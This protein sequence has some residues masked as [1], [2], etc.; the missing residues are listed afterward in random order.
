MRALADRSP[1][2]PP[3]WC[4]PLGVLAL[5]AA[6]LLAYGPAVPGPFVLDDHAAIQANP[7]LRPPA[8]WLDA[9]RPPA[10]GSTVSG[11]PLLNASFALNARWGGETAADFRRVNLALHAIAAALLFQLIRRTLPRIAFP[12][13]GAT[14]VAWVAAFGWALHPLQ[15]SAVSYISQRAEVL[16][17]TSLL[18]LLVALEKSTRSRLPTAWAALAVLASAA[19]LLSKETAVV[20]PV[21][22]LLYDRTFLAGSLRQAWHR[23]RWLHLG[24]AA[25]WILP[26]TLWRPGELRGGTV[27]FDA[28]PTAW[29]HLQ[30]QVYAVGHYLKQV[31]WPHPLVFD[32]GE[33][34]V[35]GADQLLLPLV[36][37]TVLVI[38]TGWA[39]RRRPAAGFCGAA[40][41][42][43]LAPSTALPIASQ[44]IAEHRMYLPLAAI[45]GCIAPALARVAGP[46]R[47]ALVLGSV[48]LA[49]GALTWQRN[50]V[51]RSDVAL[52]SDTVHRA[53]YNLRAHVNLGTAWLEAGQ[54]EDALTAYRTAATMQPEDPEIQLA[55]AQALTRLGRFAEAIRH[56][57][58]AVALAPDLRL[59]HLHLAE[60]YR[61]AGRWADAAET[62][63][64][65]LRL[66][67][68]DRDVRTIAAQALA[69]L[70]VR[71]PR[72][73]RER[74][75]V[76]LSRARELAP[77]DA[78]IAFTEGNGWAAAGEFHA[79]IEAYRR[80]LAIDATLVAARNNLAN[81]LLIVGRV[82]EAIVEYE[83]VLAA[84]PDDRSVRENLAAA[85]GMH[86]RRP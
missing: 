72:H 21:L 25:T 12:A 66:A 57:E 40:I 22:A 79:A 49:A 17:A 26:A 24:L 59:A 20:G 38:A 36:A 53:P 46:R 47:A 78:G 6:V 56:G 44:T 80:A 15:N 81:A 42:L 34:I 35:T 8:P 16:A 85:R 28:G 29:Q 5:L 58:R 1:S 18:L 71:R 2:D 62:A 31:L 65:A 52:W 54:L 3:P 60:A 74:A 14:L 30:T 32:H 45:V 19:G 11:R 4:V 41:F 13:P 63:L 75:L 23:R 64:V 7:T 39:W 83:Q 27:G 69:E 51:F 48:T 70:A 50:Q 55:L 82:E 77:A 68:D 9:L 73:E 61:S 84:R 86:G 43:L 37:I 67:P 76:E 33:R 10:G